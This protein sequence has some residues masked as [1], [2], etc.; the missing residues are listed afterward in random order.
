MYTVLRKHQHLVRKAPVTLYKPN[1]WSADRTQ[2]FSKKECDVNQIQMCAYNLFN[3]SPYGR[4]IISGL[5]RTHLKA[6]GYLHSVKYS[7]N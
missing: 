1:L 5:L 7:G 3:L 2:R 4:H 6:E